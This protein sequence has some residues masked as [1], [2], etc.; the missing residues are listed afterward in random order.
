MIRCNKSI[1]SHFPGF[2][3]SINSVLSLWPWCSWREAVQSCAQSQEDHGHRL[4][5]G[6]HLTWSFG[7]KVSSLWPMHKL[8]TKMFTNDAEVFQ[9][10]QWESP[11]CIVKLSIF[12]MSMVTT[13]VGFRSYFPSGRV[14]LL[15][16]KKTKYFLRRLISNG[17]LVHQGQHQWPQTYLFF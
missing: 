16:L 11:C 9:C 13:T 15:W 6:R 2:R 8:K 4:L 17:T 12:E 7:T 10:C 5:D 3:A 1:F 14:E